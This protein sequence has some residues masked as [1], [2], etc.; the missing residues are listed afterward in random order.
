MGR[1]YE[2]ITGHICIVTLLFIQTISYPS[3]LIL[4]FC[5][6][7][8]ANADEDKNWEFELAPFYLWAV[9]MDGDLTTMGNTSQLKLDFGEI[10]DNLEGLFKYDVKMYGP[11][12]GV[13]ITW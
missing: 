6:L 13:N 11:V 5:L 4:I 9:H 8:H 3:T 1:T 10:L 7:G 12:L 2:I